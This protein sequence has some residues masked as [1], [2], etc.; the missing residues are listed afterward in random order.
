MQGGQQGRRLRALNDAFH[1]TTKYALRPVELEEFAAYFPGL[2]P[3]VIEVVYDAYQQ[4][5]HRGRV[6]AETDFQ[7]ICEENALRDKLYALEQLCE[8]QGIGD[9]DAPL[10]GSQQHQAHSMQ[11]AALGEA[12]HQE[13]EQLQ[14]VL[15]QARQR[16]TQLQ[17]ELEGRQQ[18]LRAVLQKARPIALANQKGDV[19]SSYQ[20]NPNPTLQLPPLSPHDYRQLTCILRS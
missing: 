12:Q 9:G 19:A 18:Q 4:A 13:L 3:E 2:A 20:G 10:G 15:Y 6:L 11:L 8:E 16:Q 17:A 14:E 1:R 7:Q 5:L